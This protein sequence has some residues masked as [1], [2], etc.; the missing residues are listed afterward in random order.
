MGPPDIR[1]LNG[2]G[3]TPAAFHVRRGGRK[4]PRNYLSRTEQRRLFWLVMPP[5]AVAVLFGAWLERRLRGPS[6]DDSGPTQVDTVLYDVS[7]RQGL[8]GLTDSATSAGPEGAVFIRPNRDESA[9]TEAMAL[10]ANPRA[11]AAVRDDTVFREADAEAWFGLLETLRSTPAEALRSS[12]PRTVG[13]NE[14]FAQPESFRGRLVRFRGAIRRIE[15]LAAPANSSNIEG[16]WQA[17]VRPQEGP[18]SPIVVYF[19]ELPTGWDAIAARRG[20]A[21]EVDL[22]VE[23]IGYFFKRW[24]YRATDTIRTA[25][26]VVARTPFVL[27]RPSADPS[28]RW[29]GIAAVSFMAGVVAVAAVSLWLLNR[30]P[31][32]RTTLDRFE[33]PTADGELATAPRSGVSAA[34]S[35]TPI[36]DPT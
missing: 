16:Y 24:A 21:V 36:S 19:L 20:T 6:T 15:W 18:P 14:L 35:I 27:A 30:R 3:R 13:F 26:L 25:P 10:G 4:P 31:P 2:T 9:P 17:W 7:D 22:P 29:L 34:H 8:E 33:P 1:E 23:I 32:R 11:L 5:A 12:L 28:S